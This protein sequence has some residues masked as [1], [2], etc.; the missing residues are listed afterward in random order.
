MKRPKILIVENDQ[1]VLDRISNYLNKIGSYDFYVFYNGQG[2]MDFI[3]KNEVA[4]VLL[5]EITQ[6]MDGI[7]ISK[8]IKEKNPWTQIILLGALS[9]P[10]DKNRLLDYDID[11]FIY[12]PF[13]LEDFE[14]RIK[15]HLKIYQLLINLNNTSDN[16]FSILESFL[17]PVFVVNKDLSMVYLN[18]FFKSIYGSPETVEGME[19]FF[20]KEIIPVLKEEIAHFF[21]TTLQPSHWLNFKVGEAFYRLKFL[22]FQHSSNYVMAVLY[23]NQGK[24]PPMIR[25][26]SLKQASYIQKNLMPKRLPV[27]RQAAF[28]AHIIPSKRI[29]GDLFLFYEK[30]Q[31]YY[32]VL[33]DILGQGF[34]ASYI[35]PI[36]SLIIRNN[37]QHLFKEN[38][39]YFI[40]S[41]NRDFVKLSLDYF[42]TAIAGVLDVKNKTLSFVS[43][44]HKS[45]R[46]FYKNGVLENV[47]MKNEGVPLGF[48]VGEKDSQGDYFQLNTLDLK[49]IQKIGFYTDGF[50]DFFH[51]QGRDI[52]Y[53]F[54]DKSLVSGTKKGV[55]AFLNHL[56]IHSKDDDA[57]LF[58]INLMPSFKEEYYLSPGINPDLITDEILKVVES[59]DF[60][61]AEV[62]RA[63]VI[64]QEM[65]S[66]IICADKGK[67]IMRVKMN[68]KEIIFSFK[69]ENKDFHLKET[70]SDIRSMLRKSKTF[71]ESLMEDTCL[72][73]GQMGIYMALESADY[74]YISEKGRM[75]SILIKKT[76]TGIEY[77][78]DNL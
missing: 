71:P 70:F 44:G 17:T 16:Y 66:S 11:D 15:S 2:L 46:I 45:P 57:S 58:L 34:S 38:L 76:K 73:S 51:K 41:V 50:V 21:E 60:S 43:A 47:S 77:H 26:D 32:F 59:Y 74:F 24:N 67:G 6:E 54:L 35:L 25:E 33:A 65:I 56:E 62:K 22:R 72:S 20:P 23:E 68:H 39:K 18:R 14:V 8:A 40:H 12:K 37:L 9:F 64:I 75:V 61:E 13:S 5:D 36:L 49:E 27:I 31:K 7:V 28:E 42:S 30:K 63:F 4:L 1:I 78:S 29:G 69:T 19:A 48:S 53:S 3:Q 52:D 10:E 55:D